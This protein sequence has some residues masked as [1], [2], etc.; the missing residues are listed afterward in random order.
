MIGGRFE[1]FAS[2][3]IRQSRHDHR[4]SGVAGW[5]PDLRRCVGGRLAGHRIWAGMPAVIVEA[6]LRADV[7]GRAEE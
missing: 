2:R 4:R 6:H 1:R 3:A 7:G 5:I